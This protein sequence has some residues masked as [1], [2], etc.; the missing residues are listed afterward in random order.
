MYMNSDEDAD[1]EGATSTKVRY[2]RR[3]KKVR[4]R[5]R[6]NAG[7]GA[8]PI[9]GFRCRGV[10]FARWQLS[11][12]GFEIPPE[13]AKLVMGVRGCAVEKLEMG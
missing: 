13:I 1:E 3:C 6:C 11:E 7:E 2:R 4:R 10:L 9:T 8:T 12:E 5:R